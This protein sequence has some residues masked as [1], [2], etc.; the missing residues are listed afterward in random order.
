M[1][2]KPPTGA[3]AITVANQPAS[4]YRCRDC[5]MVTAPL[6]RNTLRPN[7]KFCDIKCMIFVLQNKCFPAERQRPR[8]WWDWVEKRTKEVKEDD[9]SGSD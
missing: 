3:I 8:G 2:A 9:R 1:S 4:W 7:N 5:G 6:E